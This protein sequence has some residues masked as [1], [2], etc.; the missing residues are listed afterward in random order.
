MG[1][2]ENSVTS[3]ANQSLSWRLSLFLG[4][5]VSRQVDDDDLEAPAK[6]PRLEADEPGQSLVAL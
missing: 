4:N 1:I 2:V 3:Q 5:H 6:R